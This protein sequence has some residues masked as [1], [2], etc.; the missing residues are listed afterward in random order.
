MNE[1]QDCISADALVAFA[2]GKLSGEALE[3][4]ERH[5]DGCDSCR[6]AVAE[7][8]ALATGATSPSSGPPPVLPKGTVVGRYE[9]VELAGAGG[10]GV[11]YRALD[12]T[13]NR[14]VALKLVRPDRV[15]A[16][17]A[18]RLLFEA[19]AMARVVHPEVLPV[20]DAG[21]FNDQLFIAMEWVEGRTLRAALRS[22][23]R[24][25]RQTLEPFI[26]A[27][28][29]LA[30]AHRAGLVHRD[31]KPENVLVGDDGRLRVS[32]FGLAHDVTQSDALAGTV[33]YIA[34]EVLRGAP[35]TAASDQYAFCVAL[36]EALAGSGPATLKRVVQRGLHPEP[37][38]RHASMDGLV[39][40][41]ERIARRRRWVGVAAGASLFTLAAVVWAA[42]PSDALCRSGPE[43]VATVW[44][45]GRRDALLAKAPEADRA[46]AARLAQLLDVFSTR[47][48]AA[49][50]QACEATRVS[51]E[52][53]DVLL[54]L[55][56]ACLQQRLGGVDA[57][58]LAIEKSPATALAKA[59]E[60]TQDAVAIGRCADAAY[61]LGGGGGTLDTASRARVAQLREELVQ[62]RQ[63]V[64]LGPLDHGRA[65]AEALLAKSKTLGV[66]VVEGEAQ[67]LLAEL[68]RKLRA[69][70]SETSA[71][72][73]ALDAAIL[74]GTEARA[75]HLVGEA[76]LVK[77][78]ACTDD[79]RFDEAER[80]EKNLA[81]NLRA[82]G[83]DPWLEARHH[84]SLGTLLM[85]RGKPTESLSAYAQ[86]ERVL[87]Q[88]PE[89]EARL[90]ASDLYGGQAL[91]LLT[92]G[93]IARGAKTLELA[94]ASAEQRFGPDHSKLADM[95]HNLAE[96]ELVRGELD[97]ATRHVEA[98]GRIWT[99]LHGPENPRVAVNEVLG[100]LVA[101]A[102]GDLAKASSL[103]AEAKRIFT[104]HHL[105]TQ[106][107]FMRALCAEGEV[108]LA[109][110]ADAETPLR[111]GLA[112]A[113]NAAGKYPLDEAA[114]HRV[115]GDAL[116]RRNALADARAEYE[117]AIAAYAEGKVEGPWL[118]RARVGLAEV[119]LL[120]GKADAAR[121]ALEA[122]LALLEQ[123]QLDP[124][125]RARAKAALSRAGSGP[126][127]TAPDDE[128]R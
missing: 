69:K 19:K 93:D 105:E 85:R 2:R 23:P 54:D 104:L 46:T 39:A 79:A 108:A 48:S 43:K 15:R 58:L 123:Q 88:L 33:G 81:A 103:I 65:T 50:R 76:W 67:L 92:V 8:A 128:A 28:R 121:P 80:A 51:G 37:A 72:D 7:V 12:P 66:K 107:M 117:K 6:S 120:E 24:T 71:I 35:A 34:P 41:L 68:L 83:S 29:G 59:I 113:P 112:L 102:R 40:A 30:A 77:M 31:F 61:L 52:Q 84:V 111:A 27:G 125:M 97:S 109:S 115:L 14:S 36:G 60:A 127:T 64:I 114:C 99:K 53:S 47:W 44:N 75:P 116:L 32:D 78:R 126:A 25:W 94:I 63:R 110:G 5:L 98:A 82:I 70:K 96:A 10:M 86:A 73:D 119:D 122:S 45:P 57:L 90:V 106:F 22:T 49:H 74:A 21:T 118:A 38:Q 42:R 17:T 89:E 26:R 13:L 100:A 62:A 91:V 4:V 11:I 9:I 3:T 18:D 101:S 56:M 87:P 55:K 20:Y 16:D 124:P 95:H 1:A